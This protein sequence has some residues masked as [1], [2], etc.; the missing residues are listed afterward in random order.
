MCHN[1]TIIFRE[2][3][4]F[5][6]SI[7]YYYLHIYDFCIIIHYIVYISKCIVAGEEGGQWPFLIKMQ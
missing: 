2:N 5:I 1:D 6:I 3:N 4:V 7:Y